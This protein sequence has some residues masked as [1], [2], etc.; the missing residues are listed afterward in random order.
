MIAEVLLIKDENRYLLEHLAYNAAAGIDHFF[1]Y[2]NLSDTPVA[3][4]LRENARDFLN[5]CTVARYQGR[6]NTQIDCYADYLK[7]HRHVDWTLFCDTDE[8]FTGNIRDA[9]AEYGDKYNCLS[10]SPILHGCNG[11]VYD[12]GGGMFERFAADIIDPAHH[13][14][15]FV[16]RT[17]DI[18]SISNVHYCKMASKQM[19]YLTAENYPQCVLHHFRF[20]SFEEWLR[21]IGRG[22]ALR[23]PQNDK[24]VIKDFFDA[25]PTVS[26]TAPEVV[27]LMQKQGVN[28]GTVQRYF[29]VYP[30]N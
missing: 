25:N 3:D 14:Y 29:D 18:V 23:P 20:R 22:R 17:A 16:A 28:L 24:H 1:I 2:D 21:K 19:I 8:C 12:D 27:A 6:G 5:I 15:K 30:S 4:F 10:F 9:V 13:W 11:K 26:H 7:R